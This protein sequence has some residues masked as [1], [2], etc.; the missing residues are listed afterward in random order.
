MSTFNKN[1]PK[2][3]HFYKQYPKAS[4]LPLNFEQL[5]LFPIEIQDKIFE[6]IS[7]LKQCTQTEIN[8]IIQ[9][10]LIQEYL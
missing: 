5:L 4:Q 7:Y 10:Y 3:F 9:Y 1:F 8:K 6:E 2:A